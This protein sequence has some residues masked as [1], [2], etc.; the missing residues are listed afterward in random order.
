VIGP[1]AGGNGVRGARGGM[2]FLTNSESDDSDQPV[3]LLCLQMMCCIE[4]SEY[5]SLLYDIKIK[6]VLP[7]DG[8]LSCFNAASAAETFWVLG[9][10]KPQFCPS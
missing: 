7:D 5:M 1:Q 8:H 9:G 4:I 10:C 3:E 2:E 6:L